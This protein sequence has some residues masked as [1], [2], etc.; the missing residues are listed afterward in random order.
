[1]QDQA[2][3]DAEKIANEINSSEFVETN[4]S[5]N[6]EKSR[7][8]C[9]L[10]EDMVNMLVKQ[11]QSELSNY[12]LYRTFSAYFSRNHLYKLALYYKFRSDEENTHHDWIFSY[13]SA[14]DAEFEYPEIKA[15]NVDIKSHLTPFEMTVDKEIETTLGIYQIVNL[16]AEEGD[17]NTFQWL[18]GNSSIEG[19]LISEQQEE[20]TLSRRILGLARV[21]TDW[22]T[23]QD[24]IL[25]Y[26]KN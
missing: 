10:S 8:Q 18:H 12:H 22:I 20:E 9:T 1:M 2:L 6:T 3:Q 17:W 23:K 16:A 21:D 4:I 25:E 15:S 14:C 24:A 5:P 26:Y 13:L 7:R 11:L 19:K